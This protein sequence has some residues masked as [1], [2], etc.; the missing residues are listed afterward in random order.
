MSSFVHLHVHSHYSVLDGL[1]A[2]KQIAAFA[3]E[4]RQPAIAVTDHRNTAAHVKFYKACRAAGVKPI[5][6]VEIQETDDMRVK[7][8]KERQQ[9]GYDDYHLVLLPVN[10]EGYRNLLQAVSIAATEGYFDKTEQITVTDLAGYGKGIIALSACLAGRI[11]RLLLAGRYHDACSWAAYFASI[12]DGF[13]MELQT[14]DTQEQ[15]YVNQQLIRMANELRIPLVVTCDAHYATPDD[16]LAHDAFL[17]IQTGK[18]L[19]DENR[20]RFAGGPTYYL[21]RPEEVEQWAKTNGIPYQALENTLAIAQACNVDIPIGQ[22]HIPSFP[23]PEGESQEDYLRRWCLQ[24]LKA[25]F[26]GHP[27]YREYA[28]RLVYELDV[29]CTKGYAGYFLILADILRFCREQGIPY[30]DGRGSAAGCLVSYLLEITRVDPLQH[31]LYFDRFLNPERPSMP[32]IDT[33]ISD[34]RRDEVIEYVRQRYGHVAQIATYN[35]LHV[36]SAVR[37]I[38]RVLGVDLKKVETM[39]D[40]VPLKMPDQSEVTWEKYT[41]ALNDFSAAVEKW[42][43]T[44]AE[45]LRSKAAK[46][47]ELAQPINHFLPVLTAIQGAVRAVGI[48]AAGVLIAPEPLHYWCSLVASPGRVVCSL[49]MDDVDDLGLLK[50]DLLGLRT[51]SVVDEIARKVG[52]D[53]SAIPLDDQKTLD[54]YRQGIT[55][56]IFQLSGDGITRYTRQVKPRCFDDLVDILALYRPGPLDAVMETGRTIADQYIYNREHPDQITYAHPDLEPILAP[57]HG[58]LIY[59]EQVM[60]LC[61]KLAG[62]TLGG[63]DSF[64]RVIGKKKVDEVE[65]LRQEFVEGGVR[66]GYPAELMELLFEQIKKFS[67]YAFNKSH[68]CSYA[69]LSY[70]TAYLKA[71]YPAEFMTELLSSEVD[72]ADKVL[73]NIQECRRL[74]IPI[75]PVDINASKE[76]FIIGRTPEGIPAIRYAL[77]A[78]KGVGRSAAEEVVKHQPY[79]SLADFVERVD[80]RP[81]HRKVV[82]LLIDAGCFD[83]FDP[84]RY[85]VYNQYM[86]DLRRLKETDKLRRKDEGEWTDQKRLELE[87]ALFGFYM[88]SHPAADLPTSHWPTKPYDKL[89]PLSGLLLEVREFDDKLGRPMATAVLDTV[90]G[91]A[92]VYIFSTQWSRYRDLLVKDKVVSM[93]AKKR[94]FRDLLEVVKVYRDVRESKAEQEAY[95]AAALR[96]PIRSHPAALGPM[97]FYA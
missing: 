85:R 26:A 70:K 79:T 72:D 44:E 59:Q 88:S 24:A 96:V 40:L 58:V 21:W 81:V 84:N 97:P 90:F 87:K 68:S 91:Q 50:V 30:G 20:L 9:L 28:D 47:M 69:L 2:P 60:A 1:L 75:L 65:K 34:L 39:A 78:I 46:F 80:G 54:L 73:A 49:D 55:H 93:L 53:L 57:T 12:F 25:R 62:Y 13:Y 56:G 36:K 77:T 83:C 48:H 92:K 17:C 6:G 16:A 63:A 5:L 74:G 38:G 14:N 32:D 33:D 29:I 76:D 43:Q 27:R 15:V 11:P 31:G 51:V 89:F 42:G 52:V 64:R 45:R 71:H 7:S 41:L 8:R 86:F 61:Q 10:Q 66:N 19:T 3:A 23:L 35:T 67:G 18:K 37:D 82:A 22:Q 94:H 95:L 4:H